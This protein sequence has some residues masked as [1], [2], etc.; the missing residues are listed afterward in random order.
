MRI[1][2]IAPPGAGKG[3][4]GALLADH[5]GVPHI[6]AGD[7]LREQLQ[8]GTALGRQVRA[9]IARGELVPDHLILALIFDEL[10]RAH[11][12]FVLD[13]FPRTLAQAVAARNIASRRGLLAQLAIHLPVEDGEIV[14]RLL[15][16][17]QGRSD[18]TELVIRRRLELYHEVS[19]PLI[20]FYRRRGLLVDI[21]GMRPVEDVTTAVFAAV[22]AARVRTA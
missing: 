21:D 5:L 14:R 18:D 11:D 22:D 4:Q 20:D 8:L 3:T 9:V 13:G 12:G 7:L 17:G 10:S 19:T 16:R 6:A 2:L 1:L 15:M